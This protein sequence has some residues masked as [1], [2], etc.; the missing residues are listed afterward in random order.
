MKIILT[1]FGFFLAARCLPAPGVS[2]SQGCKDS[3]CS[4]W[5][6]FSS[7]I[8]HSLLD[9]DIGSKC[10]GGKCDQETAFGVDFSK[11]HFF[12]S[13]SSDSDT[14]LIQHCE[15]SDCK[16]QSALGR[17][18]RTVSISQEYDGGNSQL[19]AVSDGSGIPVDQKRG[20]EQEKKT[21]LC[22]GGVVSSSCDGSVCQI[23]CSDNTQ[24]ESV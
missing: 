21:F 4:Q 18:K 23:T 14:F 5:N 20:G 15:G 19:L 10:L 16:Q 17:K 22:S 6:G 12:S 13:S 1:L 11:D 3:K 9:V 7:D 2:I 8:D 24:V